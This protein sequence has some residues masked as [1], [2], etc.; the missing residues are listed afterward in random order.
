M[1]EIPQHIV[2]KI[3]EK[4][5]TWNDEI[6][7][8]IARG[9]IIGYR[10]AQGEI[11]RLTDQNHKLMAENDTTSEVYGETRGLLEAC[12]SANELLEQEIERLKAENEKMSK[13]VAKKVLLAAA[14]LINEDRDEA[15]HHLYLI[16]DPTM[17]YITDPWQDLESIA[18]ETLHELAKAMLEAKT[19]TS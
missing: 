16:A 9:A 8:H 11:E 7:P 19:K 6:K 5:D 14:A 13:G 12:K 17:K 10:L 2:E 15:Y 4:A 18:G 1:S 3:K